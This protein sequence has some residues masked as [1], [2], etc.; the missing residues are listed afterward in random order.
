MIGFCGSLAN[1]ASS[2]FTQK[3]KDPILIFPTNSRN[4]SSHVYIPSKFTTTHMPKSSLYS[5]VQSQHYKSLNFTNQKHNLTIL[6]IKTL[7]WGKMKKE[8]LLKE[9][10]HHS[11]Y[12]KGSQCVSNHRTP[13]R[14]P[15]SQW[16]QFV[17][18]LL[19]SFMCASL[20]S[21]DERMCGELAGISI[22]FYHVSPRD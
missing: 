21:R 3:P 8:Y 7:L 14:P 19:I 9:Q 10:T 6:P 15:P 5:F 13:L 12:I 18:I 22:S 1:I 17:Y 2:N 20:Q 4:R 16:V 11:R